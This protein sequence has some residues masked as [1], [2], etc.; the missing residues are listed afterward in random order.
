MAV[1]LMALS[2]SK[3]YITPEDLFNNSSKIAKTT[4]RTR[5][6]N[7]EDSVVGL[8]SV[9]VYKKSDFEGQSWFVAHSGGRMVYD[10]IMI[11]MYFDCIETMSVGDTVKPSRYMFS[12]IFSSDSNASTYEYSG[13]IKLAGK[14]DDYVILRFDKVKVSCSMGD[15]TTDGYL[16]CPLYEEYEI[17]E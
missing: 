2:C 1:A 4:I 17:T 7:L 14:G 10:A 5:G 12:F 3:D 13:K 8:P 6:D 11:S 15:C 9:A 16:Y